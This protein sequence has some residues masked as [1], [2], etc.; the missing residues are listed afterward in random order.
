MNVL[1]LRI[2][3]LEKQMSRIPLRFLIELI[4]NQTKIIFTGT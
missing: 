1:L 4:G 3:G 2:V